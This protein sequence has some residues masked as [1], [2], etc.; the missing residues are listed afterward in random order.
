MDEE[1]VN[2]IS[3]KT[4]LS[5]EMSQK[6]AETT[7]NFLK[8]KLPEPLANEIDSA[9]SNSSAGNGGGAS[10]VKKGFSSLFGKKE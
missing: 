5:H 8:T 6:A 7:I 2:L 10:A 4:G 1:L 9:L 3:Q